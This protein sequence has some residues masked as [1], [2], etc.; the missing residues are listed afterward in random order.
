MLILLINSSQ[1]TKH[2]HTATLNRSEVQ[3]KYGETLKG[4]NIAKLADLLSVV[5]AGDVYS[6]SEKYHFMH[7]AYNYHNYY[8][9]LITP[10]S[11]VYRRQCA[12][13]VHQTPW[14]SCSPIV[15]QIYV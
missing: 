4:R 6:F 9:H 1:P 3:R 8:N 5:H 15:L 10:H 12:K 2:S 11:P 13:L 7:Y 14:C